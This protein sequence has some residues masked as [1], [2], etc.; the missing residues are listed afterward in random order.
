MKFQFSCQILPE[1]RHIYFFT[2]IF[3]SIYIAFYFQ[4][5]SK[6]T[7]E[8]EQLEWAKRESEREEKER[9]KRLKELQDREDME[10]ALALKQSVQSSSEA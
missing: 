4:S 6:A 9:Q 2:P 7:N 3:D 8:D 10:V 5:T 1:S